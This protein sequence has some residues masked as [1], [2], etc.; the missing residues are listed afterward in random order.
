M[1]KH[2]T[3]RNKQI[4]MKGFI[5]SF[6][7]LA[8]PIVFF[9]CNSYKQKVE[10]SDNYALVNTD[11]GK[12]K[13]LIYRPDIIRVCFSK[14]KDS[15][16]HNSLSIIQEPKHTQWDHSFQGNNLFIET[17]S[18]KLSIDLE[19]YTIDITNKEGKKFITDHSRALV[20]DTVMGEEVY[21]AHQTFKISKGEG[22]YGLGQHQ[23]GIMNFRNDT[24][25]LIQTN[26]VAV[27]PFIV[28]TEN[29]GILWDNYSKTTYTGNNEGIGFS[30]EVSNKTDYYFIGG[31]SIDQVISG[32][33]WLTGEA[34][35]FGKWAYGYWQSKERYLNADDLMSIAKEY[36]DRKI[37]IDNIVQDWCY[38]ANYD[39]NSSDSTWKSAKASWS[40]MKFNT[41]TYPDPQKTI[42][43]LHEKYNM[44]YMISI[45]PALGPETDIYREMKSLGYLYPPQHWS[46][47]YLY[48]AF[49]K[50]ARD[51]YWEHIKTGLMKYGV[52]ALWMDGTEPELGD[53]HTFDVSENNIKKFGHNKLGSMARYL[54]AFSLM[55]TQGA[56]EGFRKDF[57]NK[58]AFILTRSA[59]TGQQRN[60]AVTWSGDI[61]ARMDVFRNQ[62]SSGINFCMAGI[63]YWTTDIGAFFLKEHD[64]GYGPGLYPEGH[65]NNSY[66]ELYV[67]WFQYGA[68]CPIFRSHGTHTPREVWRFGEKGDWAYDALIKFDN[69][70]YRLMPYIY[71]LAWQVTDKDYTLMRGLAM[72]Y[73]HDT[74]VFNIDNQF[75]FGPSILVCPVT[76]HQYFPINEKSNKTTNGI[77]LYLPKGNA[78]F[79]FWTGEKHQGGQKIH[80]ETPIDIMPLY[81]KEGSILPMGPF[82]QYADEKPANPIELRIYPGADANFSLYED[83][84]DNYNYEKGKYALINFF[85]DDNKQCLTISDLKGEFKGM[86]KERIFNIVL[87]NKT[88]NS[89]L[90]II[91]DIDKTINY[92]GEKTTIDFNI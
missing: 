92:S 57:P 89:G 70:R 31:Q 21:N 40:S 69:L 26:T 14:E 7:I 55:T 62:I 73:A 12:I 63:P 18:L 87:I 84:N 38:W 56:Y 80:R 42:K 32:Y 1:E 28:S 82:I 20:H 16:T 53:Q 25:T 4:A 49:N 2:I 79:D 34:P 29:Y 41:S 3:K 50:D 19:Q 44:H 47:G 64:M 22:I 71:S 10:F 91:K 27:N 67:R 61:N 36:R 39:P 45:W 43:E 78:W 83:E 13:I 86:L 8:L 81:I 46:S 76:E 9:S 51:I 90:N 77:D 35:M 59:F 74:E 52:D 85:W 23:D 48:D 88:N 15:L 24:V 65:T 30:S 75:M 66:R 5:K 11:S 6:F 58:R 60:A 72:D 54:N 68:F 33:R 37:P 17:D